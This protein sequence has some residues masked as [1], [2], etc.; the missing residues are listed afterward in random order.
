MAGCQG[1]LTYSPQLRSA[2]D[3]DAR[4][5]GLL[6]IVVPLIT[7]IVAFFFGQHAGGSQAQGAIK[8]KKALEQTI[9]EQA[10]QDESAKTV[11]RVM[12]EHGVMK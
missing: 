11:L 3:P 8:D 6:S 4:M 2:F 1:S 5:T 7:T 12:K 10:L 9:L